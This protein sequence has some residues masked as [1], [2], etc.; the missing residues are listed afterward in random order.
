[1]I[2][3]KRNIRKQ[4]ATNAETKVSN[5]AMIPNRTNP[6]DDFKLVLNNT[7]KYRLPVIDEVPP[8]V[9]SCRLDFVEPSMT[10][11]GKKAVDCCYSLINRAGEL[12]FMRQRYP[13][14]S[15]HYQELVHALCAAGAP[16]GKSITEAVG[17]VE[18]VKIGYL[19]YSDIG[20]ILDR[21]PYP[22]KD[23]E[24]QETVAE[25]FLELPDD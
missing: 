6:L 18:N 20:S 2:T 13:K 1:M 7:A 10:R 15:I 17:V 9:Y 4:I 22:Y 24:T 25:L 11:A 12:L 14:D 23:G 19:D 8:A 3:P 21:I 16:P 5:V